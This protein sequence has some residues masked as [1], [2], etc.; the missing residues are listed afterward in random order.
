MKLLLISDTH[1]HEPELEEADVLVHA[2]DL[3]MNGGQ[4]QVVKA[5]NWLIDEAHKFQHVVLI[6][7]NHDFLFEDDPELVGRWCSERGL[8]YLSDSGVTI[9]GVEFWGSPVQ[10]WFHDWAFNRQRGAEIRK[11]WDL[12]PDDTDV[13]IT[14]GPPSGILDLTKGGDY[15][16]CIDLREAAFRVKPK[17]HA[18]GHIHEGYGEWS[19]NGTRYYN[20]SYLDHRYFPVNKPMVVEV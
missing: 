18:F 17:V 4:V 7:G 14:H 8:T 3:T 5:L 13:L 15:A 11:H 19:A 10:P 20:A 6:A 1:G 16:G 9:D 12:I 2:G